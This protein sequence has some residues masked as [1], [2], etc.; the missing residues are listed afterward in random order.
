MNGDS[1]LTNKSYDD[2][3]KKLCVNFNPSEMDILL[4]LVPKNFVVGYD[5]N[6][7]FIKKSKKITSIIKRSQNNDYNS[8]VFTGWQIIKKDLF[9][10]VKLNNFSLN[11]LYNSAEEKNRLFGITHIGNFLHMS[12]PKS[13]LQVENFLCKNNIKL[14]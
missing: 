4:L 8:L 1:L 6:G 10:Q 7:D 2:P 12:S 5:G 14:L 9:N 3:I 11:M 13:F